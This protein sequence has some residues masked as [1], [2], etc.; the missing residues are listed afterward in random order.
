MASGGP[1]WPQ[2][3]RNPYLGI[4]AKMRTR[5]RSEQKGK[6]STLAIRLLFV[7]ALVEALISGLTFALLRFGNKR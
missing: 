7:P 2:Q 1:E 6:A 5:S 4:G 3:I